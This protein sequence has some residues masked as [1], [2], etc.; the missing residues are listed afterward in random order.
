MVAAAAEDS[1]V[2]LVDYAGLMS[3][4]KGERAMDNWQVAGAISN[5]LQQVAK[6]SSAALIAAVQLNRSTSFARGRS[7][8]PTPQAGNIALSDAFGQDA[9]WI[10]TLKKESPSIT[11]NTLAKSRN[12][13][14]GAA[15]FSWFLPNEG[16]FGDVDHETAR[17]TMNEERDEDY[18]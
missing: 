18:D 12:S 15:W 10:V 13:A 3:N 5:G 1:D 8:D 14:A 4:D 7:F 17:N 6:A 11:R 16:K 9:D 2:V